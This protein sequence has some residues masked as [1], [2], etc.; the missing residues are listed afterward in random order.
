MPRFF[1][2]L[3]LL[4]AYTPIFGDRTVNAVIEYMYG[5][6]LNVQVL[7]PSPYP[8][9]MVILIK[10]LGSGAGPA[11]NLSGGVPASG[12]VLSPD[13]RSCS[14]TTTVA[15]GSATLWQLA[16]SNN[17]P[18]CAVSVTIT[19]QSTQGYV[20]ANGKHYVAG[21]GAYERLFFNSGRPF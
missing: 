8:Q 4:L 7:N 9:P 10:A 13:G 14:F 1:V 15:S 21:Q 18:G 2:A 5:G 19:V 3:A 6:A 20:V 17:C 11:F 16:T 12:P